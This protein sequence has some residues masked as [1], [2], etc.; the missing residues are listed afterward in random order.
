MNK[1]FT[2]I[3]V[4]LAGEANATDAKRIAKALEANGIESIQHLINMTDDAISALKGIGPRAMH[5]IGEIKT[6]E[7]FKSEKKISDY[8]KMKGKRIPKT[9]KTYLQLAGATY[10]ESCNIEKI[11]KENGCKTVDDF[12]LVGENCYDGWKG[13]G[14]KRKERLIVTH[15]LIAKDMKIRKAK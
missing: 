13:I 5:V 9:F 14:P 8:K 1:T 3:F 10:L 7:R 6:R 4:E 11:V 2:D 15:N 12:M